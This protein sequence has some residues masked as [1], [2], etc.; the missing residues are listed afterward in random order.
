MNLN[1]QKIKQIS[2]TWKK[3][4]QEVR[5]VML[6]NTQKMFENKMTYDSLRISEILRTRR[7]N[8]TLDFRSSTVI[9][10][11]HV[12]YQTNK[13]E[14]NCGGQPKNYCM[15]CESRFFKFIHFLFLFVSSLL[16]GVP[17]VW[18]INIAL[19]DFHKKNA[20]FRCTFTNM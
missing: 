2:T 4:S 7:T 10:P 6:Q 13:K 20:K 5:G 19:M 16:R 11:Y 15:R 18:T 14:R 9:A 3:V 12:N 8:F 1:I 17:I